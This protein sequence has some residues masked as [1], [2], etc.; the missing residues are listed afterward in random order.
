MSSMV[1]MML[2]TSSVTTRTSRPSRSW[3]LIR[4]EHTS[5]S[6]ARVMANVS[7]LTWAQ[8]YARIQN[9]FVLCASKQE[10]STMTV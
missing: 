4:Q 1:H 7:S 6:A 3:V 8:R 9:V 5:M 2:L 10:V